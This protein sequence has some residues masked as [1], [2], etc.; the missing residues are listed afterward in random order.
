MC[1]NEIK[2]LE[3]DSR[4]QVKQA[5]DWDEEWLTGPSNHLPESHTDLPLSILKCT[6]KHPL[7]NLPPDLSPERQPRGGDPG[8]RACRAAAG[9][10]CR[11]ATGVGANEKD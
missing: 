8:V 10:Q 9:Y 4:L 5:R 2:K 1:I 7:D 3:R 6:L 11:R